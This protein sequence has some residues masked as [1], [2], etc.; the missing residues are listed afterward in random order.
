MDCD[1]VLYIFV[2]PLQV[3]NCFQSDDPNLYLDGLNYTAKE[4]SEALR[5]LYMYNVADRVSK[6]A[7]HRSPLCPVSKDGDELG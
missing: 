4:L 5:L 6:V 2:S 1:D 3:T 7:P